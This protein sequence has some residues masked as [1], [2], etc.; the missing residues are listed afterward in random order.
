ME[1]Q[2]ALWNDRRIHHVK[3]LNEASHIICSNGT[4]IHKTDTDH[5]DSPNQERA[6][7]DNK[8]CHLSELTNMYPEKF[9][10]IGNFEGTYDIVTYQTI[11]PMVNI[12]AD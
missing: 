4:T 12:L 6:N 9:E 2:E 1:N 7:Q 3:G 11:I 8:Y 10:G 5:Y